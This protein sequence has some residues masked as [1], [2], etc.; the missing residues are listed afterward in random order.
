MLCIN[1]E[2]IGHNRTFNKLRKFYYWKS[3][4]APQYPLPTKSSFQKQSF[5]PKIDNN[6]L[7]MIKNDNL[8]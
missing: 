8:V 5:S 4:L 1:L 2:Y 7:K 6:S 3:K